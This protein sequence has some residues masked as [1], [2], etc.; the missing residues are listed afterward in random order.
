MWARS[1]VLTRLLIGPVQ[2]T[3]K[4]DDDDPENNAEQKQTDRV[5]SRPFQVVQR[6]GDGET[7]FRNPDRHVILPK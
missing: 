6:T 7:M 3:L 2:L 5:R 1:Q 4:H